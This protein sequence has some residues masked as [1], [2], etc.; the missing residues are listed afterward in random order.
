MAYAD[1]DFFLALIK[2]ED[3]LKSSAK[4]A[5]DEFEGD[6]WTSV[7]TVLE[8]SLLCQRE[9]IDLERALV[10]VLQIAEL[11]GVEDDLVFQ[12]VQYIE[13]EGLNVFDAFHAAFCDDVMISSD[14]VFDKVLSERVEL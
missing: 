13:K 8:I 10:D 6:I 3:W 1:T 12:A 14:E 11:K 9:E 2:D 7:V 5:L 4:K